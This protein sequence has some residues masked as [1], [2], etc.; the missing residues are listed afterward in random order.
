MPIVAICGPDG[1]G[2]STLTE[3]LVAALSESR[4]VRVLYGGKKSNHRLLTTTIALF[5]LEFI[6]RVPLLRRLARAY[7]TVVFQP[8]EY[9]E[10]RARW[11]LARRFSQAGDLVLFDRFVVDRMWRHMLSPEG[12]QLVRTNSGDHFFHWLY[13]RHFPWA[14]AYLFLSPTPE[15]MFERAPGEYGSIEQ[16]AA[17]R[18]AY[19]AIADHLRRTGRTVHRLRFGRNDPAAWL[20]ETAIRELGI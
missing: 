7:Q 11:S 8:L 14:D 10:N 2:K 20:A 15:V 9:L 6:R 17:I 19:E 1:V 16:A 13:D 18:D 4:V 12:K 3:S 5:V